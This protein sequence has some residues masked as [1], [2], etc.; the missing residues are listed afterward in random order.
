MKI[1]RL[2]LI[3][4]LLLSLL[5]MQ[6]FAESTSGTLT[7][8][9]SM[10]VN[11][12]GS[13]VYRVKSLGSDEAFYQD[14]VVDSL[15]GSTIK[16]KKGNYTIQEIKTTKGFKPENPNKITIDIPHRM[17]NGEYTSRIIMDFKSYKTTPEKPNINPPR[18]TYDEPGK[19]PIYD[20]PERTPTDP[21][22]DP[23][24]PILGL[25]EIDKGDDPERKEIII[26]ED[27]K[28][29]KKDPDPTPEKEKEKEKKDTDT[30]QK[31]PKKNEG[32]NPKTSDD[33]FAFERILMIM[34]VG[35]IS[36]GLVFL[37]LYK[38]NKKDNKDE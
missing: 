18:P 27:D 22:K 21:P 33:S 2:T 11:G 30:P 31:T 37:Y 13:P 3:F 1:K 7:I 12:G 19:P 23:T 6:I 26:S 14:V 34:V 25:R 17:E 10:Q 35:G 28:D 38:R 29:D 4:T 15:Y 9:S 8:R 36:G 5:P 16:L 20:T 24:Y 32:H